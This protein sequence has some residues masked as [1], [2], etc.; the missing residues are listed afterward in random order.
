MAHDGLWKQLQELDPVET[1]VRAKCRYLRKEACFALTMLNTE[2]SID[3]AAGRIRPA[4]SPNPAS[5]LEQLCLLAYLINARDI[6]LAHKLVKA[7]SLPGGQFFFR[8]PHSLPTAALGAAFGANPKL[9][10]EAAE[11]LNPKPREFGDASVELLVLPRIPT[12]IVI[13]AGDDEFEARS[14]MLFD[15]TAAEHLPLDALW[16]AANLTAKALIPEKRSK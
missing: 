5:F 13:W 7:E 14:S 11:P 16:T 6:P 1:A 3:L 4:G 15:K 2:Y 12:T 8:G 10:F 9:L